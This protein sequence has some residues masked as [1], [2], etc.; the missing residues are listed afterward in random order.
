MRRLLSISGGNGDGPSLAPQ[1]GLDHVDA[2]VRGAR[3]AG[4]DARVRVSGEPRRLPPAIEAS[5]YRILQE[6]LTNVMKHAGPCRVEVAVRYGAAELALE[7]LD[8]GERPAQEPLP[9][10]GRGMPGMRE[11]AAVLG[12]SFEAGP[13]DGTSGFRVAAR[14]P[15][16]PPA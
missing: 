2:L 3:E 14:L 5:A 9:A 6:A 16:E 12:G 13:R 15:L 11:R 10:A 8:D 1:P 7:V 4:L